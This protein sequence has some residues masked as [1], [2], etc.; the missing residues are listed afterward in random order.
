LISGQQRQKSKAEP[1]TFKGMPAVDAHGNG[2]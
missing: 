1:S 2:G